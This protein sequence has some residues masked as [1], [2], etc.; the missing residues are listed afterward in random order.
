M[1]RVKPNNS[2]GDELPSE[3]RLNSF[4]SLITIFPGECWFLFVLRYV[5]NKEGIYLKVTKLDNHNPF[6]TCTKRNE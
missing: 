4:V 5:G 2:G 1:L 3:G 6:V